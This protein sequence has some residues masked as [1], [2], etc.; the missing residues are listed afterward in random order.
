MEP[1]EIRYE[2]KDRIAILTLH[3]PE[4]LNAF[5]LTMRGEMIEALHRADLDDAVRA[6]VVT[7]AGTAFCAGADLSGGGK[8]FDRSAREGRRIRLGDYRDG[9]GQLALAIYRCRKPVLAAINGH[10]VGVGITMTLPMD[11]RIA[12][13]DAKIGF[14]FVRRG[15]VPEA[16]SSYFLPRIVGISRAAEWVYTGRIFR[17]G[18]EAGS[19]LFSRV[20]PAAEVLPTALSIACEIARNAA[21]V[22]VA[23]S[24]ALLWQG[25]CERDP[26]SVHLN[27]SRCFFWAGSQRDA[28]EG[29][30]SFLEKREPRFS[31]TPG[32]DMPDFYPW[33][34]APWT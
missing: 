16:C 19:G 3:R 28:Y 10:A 22:S 14:V 23:L 25:L 15:V 27:D 18:E 33:W 5:T 9:G 24:K 11:I 32:E 4:V 7:G 31:M 13:E 2:V 26:E 34:K 20:V 21:P 8:T 30:Q 6:V 1:K 17:A 12:A 29:V